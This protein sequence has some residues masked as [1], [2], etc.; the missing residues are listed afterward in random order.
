MKPSCDAQ[1]RYQGVCAPDFSL[2]KGRPSKEGGTVSSCL[3]VHPIL[4]TFLCGNKDATA[5]AVSLAEPSAKNQWL[6]PHV[7]DFSPADRCYF[8]LSPLTQT[9]ETAHFRQDA[10]PKSWC[11]PEEKKICSGSKPRIWFLPI[12]NDR[13]QWL[14]HCPYRRY[15]ELIHI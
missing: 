8:S 7:G 6:T 13:D 3:Q 14:R 12:Q 4:K 11:N 2:L 1:S 15:V 10:L 5:V 9:G